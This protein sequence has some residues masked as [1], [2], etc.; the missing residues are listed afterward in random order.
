MARDDLF[1]H[2]HQAVRLGLM[3]LV[4][5]VGATDWTDPDEVAQLDASWRPMLALL[6]SHT[7]HEDRY[8]FP[9]LAGADPGATNDCEAQHREMD[10]WLA[11]IAGWFDRLVEHPDNDGG[12]LLYRELTLFTADYLRHIHEEETR[13]MGRI[14]E[15][16][17]DEEIASAREAFLADTPPDVMATALG[18]MLRATNMS[19]RMELIGSMAASAPREVVDGVLG[20]AERVLPPATVERL[21][22]VAA[23]P[24]AT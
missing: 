21:R 9:L 8:M 18:L 1:T 10:T 17:S 22:D 14:W 3:E 6:E 11:D 19:H 5:E 2:I 23:E 12:L 24:V 7:H 16:C 13:I 15:L 4:G 20:I